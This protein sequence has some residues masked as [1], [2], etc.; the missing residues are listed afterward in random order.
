M[1]ICLCL[2]ALL[3]GLVLASSAPADWRYQSYDGTAVD[4]KSGELLYRESHFLAVEGASVR[5]RLVLYRCADGRPF[6]RKRVAEMFATPWMPEFDMVDARIDYREGLDGSGEQLTVFVQQPGAAELRR[7]TIRKA[8]VDLVA[9]AGF[10]RFVRDN[11]DRLLAGESLRL[12]FLVPSRLEYMGFKVRRLREE[13]IDGR[14]AQVFRL[15]LGG[16]IGLFVSGIDVAYDQETRLLMRF[17]GLSNVRAPNGDNY[18]ARIDFPKSERREEPGPAAL[19]AA[20][21]IQLASTCG[22]KG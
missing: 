6:A 4:P 11:W 5:E 14:P 18:V 19:E 1:R 21:E 8:P 9:D 17:E 20:R 15:A 3:P 12:S 16:F 22:P 7:E 13:R 10:D 2:F